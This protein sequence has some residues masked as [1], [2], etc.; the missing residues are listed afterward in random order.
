MATLFNYISGSGDPNSK[1]TNREYFTNK[2]KTTS[3]TQGEKFMKYQK[4]IG[5]NKKEGF[6]GSL[7]QESRAIL[8]KT[9][10]LTSPK[11]DDS[12]FKYNQQYNNVL[13]QYEDAETGGNDAINN[14]YARINPQNPYL[15]SNVRFKGGEICYVTNQGVVKIYP[16]SEILNF[17]A[18]L[19]GCPASSKVIDLDVHW[20]SSYNTVG[21]NI[22]TNPPL[23]TGTPMSQ[24]QSCG[25]EGTT[26]YV[27]SMVGGN[28]TS[29]Y[30]GCF[31]DNSSSP[32]M[33]FIG[34]APP[35]QTSTGQIQNP[36]FDYPQ[37][38]D[39]SYEYIYSA[40]NTGD[41]GTTVPGWNFYNACLINNSTAWSYPIPYPNG[42]QAA[43]IQGTAGLNQF[44]YL[45]AGNYYIS[46]YA[47][48]RPT[49][50][51]NTIEVALGNSSETS[52]TVLSEI[53][54]PQSA[55]TF[56]NLP[57]TVP[58]SA[59][60]V[61]AFQ[62]TVANGNNCMAIQQV[63]ITQSSSSES[64]GGGNY[65]EATCK[66]MAAYEGY[67]YYALQNANTS[68]M[69]YCAV[70]NDYI[71]TTQYGKS[72][73]TS[74]VV[75]LWQSGTSG[76]T[77][78]TASLNVSGSLVVQNSS[79][80]AIF[81]TPNSVNLSPSYLGC[82]GDGPNRAFPYTVYN[83]QVINGDSGP[84]SW[85]SSVQSCQQAAQQ[86]DMGYFGLQDST[87]EG[88]AVCFIG[89]SLSQATEYGPAGNCTTFSDGTVNGGGWSNSVY[90]TGI[91]GGNFFVSVTDAGLLAIYLG[92]NPN[93]AQEVIWSQQGTPQAA[94]TTYAAANSITGN[95]WMP[96]GTTL[97]PGE[98]IGSPNGYCA[99]IMQPSG[100]LEFVTF[101]SVTNCA[102][103]NGS[104]VGGVGANAVYALSESGDISNMG[105]VAYIDQNSTLYPYESSNVGLANIYTKIKYFDNPNS[106]LP[107]P[108][109]TS[110]SSQQCQDLCDSNDECYGFSIINGMC[111]PK[112]NTMYPS[113][114]LSQNP[115]ATLYVRN[116]FGEVPPF[117]TDPGI[118][119][120]NSSQFSN[121]VTNGETVSNSGASINGSGGQFNLINPADNPQLQALQSELNAYGAGMN[122]KL[123]KYD[124]SNVDTINQSTKNVKGIKKQLKK[125]QNL[126][127][128]VQNFDLSTGRILDNSDVT[129]LQQNYNYM[130]WSILAV[131]GSLLAMN[132]LKPT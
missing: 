32:A 39:N 123:K 14:Y 61:I 77:G 19:N 17:T 86:N 50:L 101:A 36:S 75:V 118:N 126:Q 99:L 112:N 122:K 96:Q 80:T 89:N 29:T 68:G 110:M 108:P 45:N 84:Y 12:L 116:Q 46:F 83:G 38:A 125:L 69:G 37:I 22:P 95:N 73:V 111:Y 78:S 62:G 102:T 67:K 97:N 5:K 58:Q 8:A 40:S 26:V 87:I 130:F 18:G 48:G 47:V 127:G 81:T 53:T 65:S 103:V 124:G 132:V 88:E 90:Q 7:T 42:N 91:G 114:T 104:E 20:Q 27:N 93:D 79:G 119:N 31:A 63:I 117:G 11:A 85:N 33:T 59:T 10:P 24:A 34:G 106:T 44:L 76:Q 28:V 2:V 54:P 56:Y 100:N 30:K 107:N 41:S 1:N 15:N 66:Q 55:W 60:W 25:Y 35:Q 23:I 16:N 109:T 129:V 72:M 98:F 13:G 94:S 3:L 51:S 70:S 43:C 71:S 115:D 21:T 64:G 113:G 105:Q 82:Y 128:Q 4:K 120:I 131:G 121:Y 49:Y 74:Q 57:F 52:W 9:K 92:Q 6:T